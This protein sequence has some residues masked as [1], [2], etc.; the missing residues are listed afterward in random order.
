MTVKLVGHWERAWQAPINEFDLWIHPIHE[1]NIDEFHMVPVS[2]IMKGRVIEHHDLQEVLDENAE[3]TH[4]Y[5]DEEGDVSLSDFVHPEHALYIFGRTGLSPYKVY[6][7]P[8]DKVVR[9]E[10]N[11]NSGGFWSHQVAAMMLYD[12]FLK[13]R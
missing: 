6:A 12:R 2:G 9:I 3:L 4:V 1:F 5:F 11:A 7:R 13:T 10:S 8:Q